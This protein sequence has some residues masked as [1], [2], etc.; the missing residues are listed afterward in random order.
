MVLSSARIC[1][2]VSFSLSGVK[3]AHVGEH[4]RDLAHLAA[5]LQLVA[6][7]FDLGQQRRRDV[8][9]EGAA[10]LA[11]GGVGGEEAEEHQSQIDERQPDKRKARIEHGALGGEHPPGK[12]GREPEGERAGGEAC[13][14]SELQ[15]DDDEDGAKQQ[16]ADDF[17]ADHPVGAGEVGARE[18]LLDGLGVDGDAGDVV[19]KRRGVEVE[20]AA[21]RGA[22]QDDVAGDAIGELLVVGRAGY[23]RPRS[24]ASGSGRL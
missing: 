15:H 22:D 3:A 5:Q 21:G 2:G 13:Y 18:D 10:D 20:Q 24:A 8:V 4:H 17:E 11:L 9:A 14:R 19:A 23:P 1:G 16:E 6:V 12:A 7:R